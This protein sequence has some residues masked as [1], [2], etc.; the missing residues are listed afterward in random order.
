LLA[1][2]DTVGDSAKEEIAREFLGKIGESGGVE[3]KVES[4][5]MDGIVM[6]TWLSADVTDTPLDVASVGA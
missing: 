4:L 2:L 1:T 6:M 3:L 5:G